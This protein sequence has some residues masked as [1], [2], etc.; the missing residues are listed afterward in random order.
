MIRRSSDGPSTLVALDDVTDLPP[1]LR[2]TGP[3]DDYRI[4]PALS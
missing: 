1:E 4:R 2:A 3:P